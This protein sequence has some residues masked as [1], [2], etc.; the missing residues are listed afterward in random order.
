MIS[1]IIN[2]FIQLNNKRELNN[3][4]NQIGKIGVNCQL[5]SG[6]KI[7]F[8]SNLSLGDNIYIGPN[9]TLNALGKIEVQS[10]VIMGPNIFIHSANHNFNNSKYLPYDQFHHFKKVTICENVW[11]GANVCIAP[12]TT[13]GEG[14]IIGMGAVVSGNVPPLSILVGNP[15]QIIKTR[16]PDHYF[17]LKKEG[18]IYLAAK[19]KGEISPD[20]NTII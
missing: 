13:I 2:K 3:L 18:K 17:K 9:A 15:S 19:M 10:G 8:P 12:G 14:C 20:Y 6:L 7:S 5:S 11:I 4:T 16:D 1:R